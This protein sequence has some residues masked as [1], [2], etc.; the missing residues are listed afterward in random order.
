MKL[1]KRLIRVW[2]ILSIVRRYRLLASLPKHRLGYQLLLAIITP[3]TLPCDAKLPL[4]ER[5]KLA[6]IELGPIFIKFGQLLST[7]R[8]LLPG[9]I[10]NAL[11]DLQDNV[12]PFSGAK[13]QKIIEH[14]FKQPIKS[15]FSEFETK[16]L[17]SASVAQV[18]AATLVTGE[19]VVV[20][21]LR[22][23]IKRKITEDL[24]LL[25]GIAQ[26]INEHVEGSERFRLNE[27]VDDYQATILDE[28]DLRREAAN[29]MELRRNWQDS[30]LLYVPK[31][32]W[33]FCARKAIVVERI[34]G[35]PIADI[36][37]LNAAGTDMKELARRGVE[38]FF[39][40]V[41]RDSYFHADMHPGNI[42]VDVTTP[43]KPK[44]IAIDCGI[45][46]SLE[47]NDQRYLAE[48][49]VAFFNRDYRRVAKLHIE[50]GWVPGSTSEAEFEVAIRT[51]CEPIFGKPLHEISFGYLLINLFQTA[52]RFNMP[53]QPQLVLL[54]KTLLY[55]EGLGRQL[56]P[57]LDLWE[58]A[59]PFLE[60]W[61]EERMSPKTIIK[62]IISKAPYWREKLPQIP[63]LIYQSLI[64]D[65]DNQQAQELQIA[66]LQQQL[67]LQQQAHKNTAKRTLGLG[68]MFSGAFFYSASLISLTAMTSLFS[69]GGVLLVLGLKSV[70]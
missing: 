43:A 12:E 11:A 49:F 24:N 37:A 1:I 9:E 42:F 8:D 54:Q 31:I 21:V 46:G 20:K 34:H 53:V 15:I 18:H 52:Q 17:A 65:R 35:I 62:E 64:R 19:Q 48:N 32:Y 10:A 44:Y 22:P 39:T 56:Y 30:D 3:F 58:T 45:M 28:L 4:G 63:D 23:N 33:D 67:K 13:A 55:I 70:K 57:Q 68:L 14:V 38:I 47:A 16:A 26:W 6:L 40:Q 25:Q 51:V 29:T 69:L 60:D 41:F 50:S 36:D 7:R 66:L 61:L 59:K 2:K 5:L 27:V